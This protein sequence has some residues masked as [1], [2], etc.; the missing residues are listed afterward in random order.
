MRT[1]VSFSQHVCLRLLLEL[2]QVQ[3]H[4]DVTVSAC[5]ICIC[6]LLSYTQVLVCCMLWLVCPWPTAFSAV[7]VM[8]YQTLR[9]SKALS[10]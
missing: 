5:D 9:K 1:Y 4:D 6:S 8:A 10:H 7:I 2:S 3:S